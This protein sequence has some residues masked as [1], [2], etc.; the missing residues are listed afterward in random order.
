MECVRKSGQ[1]SLYF[2]CIGAR[3]DLARSSLLCHTHEFSAY[4]RFIFGI[5]EKQ[6]WAMFCA[7]N[8]NPRLNNQPYQNISLLSVYYWLLL[9]HIFFSLSLS[10]SLRMLA[11]LLILFWKIF[12]YEISKVDKMM[13]KIFRVLFIPIQT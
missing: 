10:L 13:I 2:E 5:G 7:C 8:R 1:I 9:F 11:L 6:I 4:N 3:L 12:L